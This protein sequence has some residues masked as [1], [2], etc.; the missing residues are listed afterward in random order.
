MPDYPTT[1]TSTCKYCGKV[2][3]MDR[4]G[5]GKPWRGRLD[6]WYSVPPCGCIGSER[7]RAIHRDNSDKLNKA[8]GIT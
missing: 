1:K 6:Y 2:Q 4:Q 3:P 8:L 5:T 7:Q